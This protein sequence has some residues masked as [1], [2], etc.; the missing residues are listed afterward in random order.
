MVTLYVTPTTRRPNGRLMR[1]WRWRGSG[2]PQSLIL[3]RAGDKLG[4]WLR[5][6]PRSSAQAGRFRGVWGHGL[7]TRY[8]TPLALA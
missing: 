3:K 6:T 8:L 4:R 2:H 1:A 7:G 5:Q